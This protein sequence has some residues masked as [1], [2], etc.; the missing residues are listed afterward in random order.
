MTI[1][2]L[3]G[4]AT[5]CDTTTGPDALATFDADAALDDYRTVDAILA[6]NSWK[7]F[8]VLGNKASL[9]RLGPV[10]VIAL[11]SAFEL[12]GIRDASDA[13]GFASEWTK[14]VAGM[15]P[16]AA[17]AP[18]ISDTHRGKTFIYDPAIDDYAVSERTGAPSNG[19]RFI[20][21]ETDGAGKPIVENEIGY[22]DLTD[23]GDT[24]VEDIA[25]RL[26]VVEGSSTVL[27]YSTTLDVNGPNGRITVDGY[28]TDGTQR[29]DFSILATG[30]DAPSDKTLDVTFEMRVDARN[31]SINGSVIGADDAAGNTGEVDLSVT[32]GSE[33]LRVDVEGTESTISGTFYLN[34][35]VFATMSGDPDNPTFVGSTGN[36]LT[37]S[38]ALVLREIVDTI[39]DVFDFF[40]DLM[41]PIEDLVVLAVIL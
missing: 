41:D 4:A 8:Q 9:D 28:L 19:A 3:A 31:F 7:N 30:S 10:P 5:A 17:N 39:E 32:H 22:F 16:V 38:E 1:A 34:G 40:E 14:L 21:Y 15:G 6:S 13:R 36:G 29:L 37:Q 25:L 11:Q 33:S 2:V 20:V 27:D 24:S 18:I 26:V 23:E 35:D 12:R